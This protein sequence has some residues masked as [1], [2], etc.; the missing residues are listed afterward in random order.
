[1]NMKIEYEAPE[2]SVVALDGADII[3]TSPGDTP[4]GGIEW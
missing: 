4:M 3:T 2:V 1:M